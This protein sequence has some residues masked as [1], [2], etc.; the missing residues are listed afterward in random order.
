LKYFKL[1]VTV[2][3]DDSKPIEDPFQDM[4]DQALEAKKEKKEKKDME[5]KK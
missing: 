3:P 1:Y 4:L 5:K 2:S